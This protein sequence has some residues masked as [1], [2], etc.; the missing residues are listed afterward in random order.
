MPGVMASREHFVAVR[1]GFAKPLWRTCQVR[2]KA[3]KDSCSAMDN[4]S[5]HGR[6]RKKE[7]L[8]MKDR[9]GDVYENKG[10]YKFKSGMLLRRKEVG[11]RGYVACGGR[12]GFRPRDSRTR[13][14]R[15]NVGSK[16]KASVPNSGSTP[17]GAMAVIL[18]AKPYFRVAHA[19]SNPSVSG[20]NARSAGPA[21][22]DRYLPTPPRGVGATPPETEGLPQ[23]Y[24]SIATEDFS[25]MLTT[26][27]WVIRDC[28]ERETQARG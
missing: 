8:K 12:T 14:R 20:G 23:S 26:C 9:T 16:Q 18:I 4:K 15:R 19:V 13:V 24:G 25:G 7:F 22:K 17:A 28:T 1:P 6:E 2:R 5:E 21:G 3:R 10:T 11:G 27:K